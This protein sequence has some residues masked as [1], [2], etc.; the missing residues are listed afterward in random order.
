MANRNDQFRSTRAKII[1]ATIDLMV[2]QGSS[3]IEMVQIAVGAS[4]SRTTLY[5]HF[6]TREAIV[7]GIFDDTIASFRS[8]MM[9]ALDAQPALEDRIDAFVGFLEKWLRSGRLLKLFDVDPGLMLKLH[10][11]MMPSAVDVFATAME[12]VFD[13]VDLIHGGRLDRNA[14][15]LSF[16]HFS[17]SLILFPTEELQREPAELMAWVIHALIRMPARPDSI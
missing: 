5:R 3:E 6:S 17:T 11:Q 9:A 12:P 1:D 14:I 13:V 15:A 10:R 7:A 16:V 4:V 8:G 2:E